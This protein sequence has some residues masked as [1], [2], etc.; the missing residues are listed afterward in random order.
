MNPAPCRGAL[1][2]TLVLA[3]CSFMLPA[4]VRAA[5]EAEGDGEN[6]REIRGFWI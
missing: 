6:P 5:G 4:P 3:I 1:A 2:L